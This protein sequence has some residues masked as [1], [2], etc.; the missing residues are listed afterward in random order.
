MP[1][2]RCR[3]TEC[4][5][6]YLVRNDKYRCKHLLMV[7]VNIELM[8]LKKFSIDGDTKYKCSNSDFC[9]WVSLAFHILSVVM[10]YS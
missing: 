4:L 5:V 1:P 2:S 8:A 7:T 9:S 3:A 6:N 10:F